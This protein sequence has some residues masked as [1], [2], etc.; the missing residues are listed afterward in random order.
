MKNYWFER[1]TNK[2]PRDQKNHAYLLRFYIEHN[3]HHSN[4]QITVMLVSN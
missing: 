3:L 4:P 1:H 2:N